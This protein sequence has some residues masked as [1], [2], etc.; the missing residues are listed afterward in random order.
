MQSTFN[1]QR[2]AD[3]LGA[4]PSDRYAR[5]CRP[6]D[7]CGLSRHEDGS[8]SAEF[9]Q[10]RWTRPGTPL[11]VGALL[12]EIHAAK[13]ILVDGPQALASPGMTMRK[14]ERLCGAPGKT[15]DHLPQRGPYS[16][17]IRSSIELFAACAQAGIALSPA[18]F[19]GGISETYPG[20]IWRQL[21]PG[22][23]SKTRV[24]GRTARKVLLELLGVSHLPHK[25]SH[26]QLDACL[27]A[28]LAAAADG[29][30]SGMSVQALGPPLS[31]TADGTW[32]E[33]P[34]V[35][36]ELSPALQTI[37]AQWRSREPGTS[38]PSPF[39]AELHER[40]DALMDELV[41]RYH[42]G[43]AQLCTYAWCYRHIFASAPAKWSQAYARQIIAIARD[44]EPVQLSG[45]GAVRLDTFIVTA[46]SH[47]P[48]AGHWATA[49]Y[50]R[51]QWQS[52]FAQAGVRR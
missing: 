27:C 11:D 50:S 12:A 2:H 7:V 32:R 4:D 35:I 38:T 20:A 34:I 18:G 8:L 41:E 42:A 24:A 47:L 44:G 17:F 33:G 52:L 40:A 22:L 9:W 25:P 3:Y 21:S 49:P 28:L 15:P 5:T 6:I 19:V 45:L 51:E 16:G 30:V 14:A 23:P 29:Q 1:A 13:A 43:D 39:P 31:R 36:A 48:S 26:D 46:S 37:V 10:W